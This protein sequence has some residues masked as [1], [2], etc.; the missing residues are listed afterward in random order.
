MDKSLKFTRTT[1]T[2]RISGNRTHSM[3][4]RIGGDS[5][6]PY[7]ISKSFQEQ[8]NRMQPLTHFPDIRIMEKHNPSL[9]PPSSRKSISDPPRQFPY[10]TRSAMPRKPR[11]HLKVR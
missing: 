2:W 11:P 7:S 6:S 9:C 5:S 4:D 3:D 8:E 10:W 1:I